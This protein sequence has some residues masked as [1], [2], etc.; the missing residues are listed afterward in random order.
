M[1]SEHQF[2]KHYSSIWRAVTPL[3][4]GFWSFENMVVERVDP[5]LLPMAPKEVRAVVNEAAFRAFCFMQ[6][7]ANRPSR[8]SIFS[9]ID[10]C[11]DES[12]SYVGRF[13]SA[14]SL[15]ASALDDEF[16]DEVAC[17]V[18]RLL[19]FFPDRRGVILRPKF[20]GC[21]LI[22][23]C[24]GDVVCGSCLYEIKAGDRAF[25][26]AD[27]RQLLIYSALAY[28]KGELSFSDVGVFNPRTG[29]AWR[30]SL[31]EVSYA[32]SGLRLSDTLSALVEHF[33]GT[34]ASR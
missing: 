32:V 14:A 16:R 2:A 28:A 21:G 20:S 18:L 9:A 27:L 1:I 34:S 17:L 3:A 6:G 29:V 5:P 19:S 7:K 13:S 8:G 4:D 25:R 12:I 11:L 24:E 15:M 23:A 30:K 10:C 26:V 33:S 31:E 22:S